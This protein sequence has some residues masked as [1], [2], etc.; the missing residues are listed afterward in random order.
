MARPRYASASRLI[1]QWHAECPFFSV[2]APRGD[3]AMP[4]D[5]TLD[6]KTL[7]FRARPELYR[8]GVGEQGVLLVR[9]YREEL[10]PLWRFKTPL[11]AEVSAAALLAKFL[12]YRGA[13]DFVG[14]DMAR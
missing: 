12:E 11:L 9:P 13:D 4:F 7:D 14:M 1:L 10:L 5:Y 6:Y 2:T 8:V 3:S